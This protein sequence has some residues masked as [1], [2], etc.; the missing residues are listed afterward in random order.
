MT[1]IVTAG[2]INVTWSFSIVP[3]SPLV[4]RIGPDLESIAEKDINIS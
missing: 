1:S 4:R 2:V 3:Y